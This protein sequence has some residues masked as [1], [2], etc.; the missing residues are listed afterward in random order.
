MRFYVL[1]PYIPKALPYTIADTDAVAARDFVTGPFPRCPKCGN[2]TRFRKW[3]PP[4]KAELETWGTE[5]GEIIIRSSDMLIAERF[6][7]IY[8]SAR[9]V[10]LSGFEPVEIVRIRKHRKLTENCPR[11]LRVNATNSV[12]A[13]DT[14]ASECEWTDRGKAACR[15]CRSGS[16]KRWKRIIIETGT[17]SGEDIFHARGLRSV[18]LV[19]AR[20]KEVCQA[21]SVKNA[22]FVPA[23]EYGHD[24]YRW[25]SHGTA[26]VTP[27]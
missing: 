21:N 24:F 11:Y 22:M 13:V 1:N 14:A 16:I 15:W 19:S 5:F 2:S 20:F 8:E 6:R 18:V 27:G 23:E 3:L 4:F 10:G 12:A 25:E 7:R 26:E 17:W 9:L